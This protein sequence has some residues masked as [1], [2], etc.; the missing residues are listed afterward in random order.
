MSEV[1]YKFEEGKDHNR[2]AAYVDAVEAGEV[3]YSS[4]GD[5][6]LI[7]DHTY[8]DENYR[9]MDI[10][11]QLVKHVVDLAIEDNKKIIPLCPFARR[12][13]NNKPEYQKIEYKG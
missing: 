7:I 8:V 6:I 9:G 10:A 5:N 2:F 4:A 13:F 11:V 1:V 12:E 3:T